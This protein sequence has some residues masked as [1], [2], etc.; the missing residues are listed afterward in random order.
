MKEMLD[1]KL[2]RFMQLEKQLADPE[3]MADGI[4]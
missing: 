2:E 3:V 4:C 1:E